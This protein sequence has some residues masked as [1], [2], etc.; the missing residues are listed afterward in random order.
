MDGPLPQSYRDIIDRLVRECRDGQGQLDARRVR[1]GVWNANAGPGFIEDQHEVNQLLAR[2]PGADREIVARILAEEFV[3]GV[4]TAL[5]ALREADL[6]PF[7]D[8]YEGTPFHDFM[9]RL[10]GWP[11]PE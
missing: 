2:M 11:W 7:E 4:H 5:V 10:D 1:A 9:G 3:A 8:G 6:E